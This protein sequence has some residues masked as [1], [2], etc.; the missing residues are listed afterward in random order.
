V[1]GR[2]G[3]KLSHAITLR[4]IRA[5][6]LTVENASASSAA[7]VLGVSQSAVSQQLQ[8]LEKILHVKLLERVGVRM[9]P[10]QAGR[11]L[12]NPVRQALSAVEQIEPAIAE[13]RSEGSGMV[14][15]GTGATACIHFLPEPLALTRA[16][17]PNLQILVVT[18]NSDEIVNAVENGSI[19]VG[20]ITGDLTR[21]NP[22][23][24]V[25]EILSE[26]L[27]AVVPKSMAHKLP[28]VLR[29]RDL[30]QLP[31]I[32][33][34]PAG[35]TRDVINAWFSGD[36]IRP[37]AAMELGSIEAIKTLVGAGLGA[38]LIPRL[39]TEPATRNVIYR[40]IAQPVQRHLC[41]AMRVDKVLDSGLR[42]LLSH[43]RAAAA[44][45]R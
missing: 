13:F 14:R 20:L 41:L 3:G 35:R 11:A 43:L 39:A 12:I 1:A 32:L 5:F 10:T 42:T 44:R 26:D 29:P 37:T 7:R 28:E 9:L 34:D 24:H 38:S 4:Q 33:F 25:E 2:L 21:Q 40:P 8:E 27:V 45:I 36:G 6:L 18:G 16:Q 22:M 23:V 30:A 31:L 15:L 19:D 17:M